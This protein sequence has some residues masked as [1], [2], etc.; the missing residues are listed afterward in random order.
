MKKTLCLFLALLLLSFVF[1]STAL[2]KTF[3][4]QNKKKTKVVE[5]TSRA[6]R[7]AREVELMAKEVR[8]ELVTL[9]FYG[10]FDWLEG[11]VEPDGTVYLRGDVTRP[12]LKKDAERRV[13]KIEGVTKVVN[14]IEVLP[15][16]PNDDRLRRAVVRALFNSN[17]P[18][19][20]YSLGAN[21][22]IHIIVNN[23]RLTLKGIV[24]TKA[25][26]DL[27]NIR[28]NGVSGLFEVK[29]E[30]QIESSS[31]KK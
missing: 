4:P 3:E 7:E 6:Q 13:Q 10:V 22:A 5:Q 29:N 16:S 31:K 20:R 12:T 19:S 24:S 28:A 14:E 11:R 30:L 9:P 27:A 23:G 1:N 17:S 18:L 21:P 25:D 26:S 2:A 15:L 8:K